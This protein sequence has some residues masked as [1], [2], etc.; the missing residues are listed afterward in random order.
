MT[1]STTNTASTI[2]EQLEIEK[3]VSEFV[4]LKKR[5]ANYLGLCPFHLE[6]T[7]SFVV[8]PSKQIYKCFGCGKS[9]NAVSFLMEFKKCTLVEAQNFLAERFNLSVPAESEMALTEPYQI[10]ENSIL[11]SVLNASRVNFNSNIKSIREFL[12]FDKLLLDFCITQIEGLEERIRNNKEIELTNVRFLPSMTLTQLRTIREHN[13]F[14]LKYE[15]INNQSLV[16]LIS[17]FTSTL[18]EIFKSSLEYLASNNKQ[19]FKSIDTDFKISLQEL[20]EFDFN[21]SKAIG[22]IIIRKKDISF[23]DMQST[24]REYKN[25]LGVTIDKNEIV[26]N[27]IFAQA[28]RH[29]IVHSLGIADEKFINQ[30]AKSTQR[31][32]KLNISLN[33]EII[34][35][36]FEIE[37]VIT[38]LQRFVDD[39]IRSISTKF[40][41]NCC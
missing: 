3:V 10:E 35:D 21:L 4:E 17:H 11:N 36:H 30:V 20:G 1:N 34:F 8:S 15:T 41:Q 37:K 32:L 38:D 12:N 13:S 14:K 31:T 16:L 29:A 23:Q 24:V 40:D 6:K 18:K 26:D 5:G 33:D 39:L 19:Y 7:P 9:G 2:V 28:S 25:Y 22:D 27:I